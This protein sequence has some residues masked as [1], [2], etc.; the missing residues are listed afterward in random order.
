MFISGAES[1]R[2]QVPVPAIADSRR[3]VNSVE[4]VGVSITTRD[5]STG[6]GYTVTVGHG[7]RV[8]QSVLDDL[9]LPELPGRDATQ[10]REIWHDLYHGKGLW[11]G[12]AGATAMAQAAVDIALWDL[13]A[14][15]ADQPLWRL[16]GGARSGDVPA[17]NTH[18]G[19]LSFGVDEL[20]AQCA[21]LVEEG[22]RAVKVKVGLP[23]VRED[24][25]R[26]RAVRRA[27]GDD[28]LLMADANQVWDLSGA[29]EAARRFD[30]VGLSWLEEPMH[31]DD[32]T[33]HRTL[34]QRSRIP[35]A[36]GE[37]LYGVHAFREFIQAGAVEVVQVDVCRVG[38]ITPWLEV[39]ALAH[40]W[41]LRVCPHCGDL[42]QVHQHLLKAIPNAWM[43]EVIP[44]WRDSPFEHPVQIEEGRCATPESPG[45]GSG[46]R[47]DAMRDYRVG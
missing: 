38:G 32:V 4:I 5:G 44:L 1:F 20:T 47:A 41:N 3:T 28:V 23:D 9:Y 12:R 26:L 15:A 2:L 30:E 11:I 8:I 6:T 14:R 25:A 19:W 31:P 34:A 18:G 33:S 16:L 35:V 17:Y 13:L 22:Y 39:A 45:A 10:V 7:G 37:H 24:Q 36:L 29:C 40:A 43:L 42:S 46:L 27:V 21:A